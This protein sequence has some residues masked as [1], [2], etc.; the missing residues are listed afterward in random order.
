MKE[1]KYGQPLAALAFL[2]LLAL[3]ASAQPGANSNIDVS[4]GALSS[5][6]LQGHTGAFPNGVMGVA[7]Q[8]TSCN[9]MA[10]PNGLNTPWLISSGS[11]NASCLTPM[12]RRHP[13]IAF[14]AARLSG[15][16]LV[17]ISDR[18]YLKHGFF[19]LSQTICGP[20]PAGSP[21]TY[22]ALQCAD[23]YGVGNNNDNFYLAPPDEVNP[24]TGVWSPCGS[25]FDRGE[26]PVAL[27]QQTDGARSLSSAQAGALNAVWAHVVRVRDADL[28]VPGSLF[29]YQA[30]YVIPS[31]TQ[32]STTSPI[33]NPASVVGMLLNE[34]DANRTNNVGSRPF[35]AVWTGATWSITNPASAILYGSILQRWTG[36]TV[37]SNTNG[38]DD[39]RLYVAVKVT[40]PSATTGLYHYEYG[41]HNRDNF[42]GVN[43]FRLPVCPGAQVLNAAFHDI[44]TNAGNDWTISVGATEIAFTAPATNPLNWNSLFNFWFDSDAAPVAGS[45]LLDQ[46]AAGPGAAQVSVSS[47]IPAGLYNQNLGPGCGIPSAPSLFAG[48]SPPRAT[49]GNGT[50]SLKT[51]GNAPS[52]LVALFISGAPGSVDLGGGC[53]LYSSSLLSV[54]TLAS[55]VCDATG[56]FTWPIPVPSD[57][58]LEGIS[59]DLQVAAF[60]S[61]G[62]Y[63]GTLNLTNGLRVRVGSATTNCP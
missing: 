17:Q 40:G 4:L 38:V 26:P 1:N 16:R 20:C 62:A 58:A 47:T 37:T 13:V 10:A 5:L 61:P 25:Q 15:D 45:I 7:M 52:A 21:G 12:E 29:Y 30:Q 27:A 54:F 59:P 51:A 55:G 49:L 42:R 46:A 57:P 22:L 19:A 36:A 50:F 28:N 63:L 11:A 18:S 31:W 33:P 23:T 2:G 35:T 8:T 43:A 48:G 14:L 6:S 32:I 53:T 3:P 34:P 56:L 24:W 60:A 41:V 44:D 9:L 39:G